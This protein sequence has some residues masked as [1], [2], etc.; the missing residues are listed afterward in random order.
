[1]RPP[2]VSTNDSAFEDS[3]IGMGSR[4]PKHLENMSSDAQPPPSSDHSVS[5]QLSQL[6]AAAWATEQE[7][8]LEGYRRSKI[9]KALRTIERCLDEQEDISEDGTEEIEVVEASS[10]PQSPG[11]WGPEDPEPLQVIQRNLRATVCSMRLRQQEQR[12]LNQVSLEKL[13]SVAQTCFVQEAQLKDMAD[14]VRNLRIENHKLGEMND[15]LHDRV[16]DLESQSTQKEVAV[17]A[18][19]SAV[20]GLEGWINNSPGPNPYQESPSRSQQRRGRYI[21]RGKGRFRGRYYIDD[22]E[23]A[24]DPGHDG[25]SDS[26]ELHDGVKAWLRGFRDVEEE[27]QKVTPDKRR[28]SES[29]RHKLQSAE[30]DWGDFETAS[31]TR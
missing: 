23:E 18:M 3:A 15:T 21:V 6:A 4:T 8:P 22:H 30:D 26:R 9:Q 14:D 25:V 24:A 10:R 1:M 19:S 27:L 20:A 31:E 7:L 5:D 12:H 11:R 2:S 16:A 13:E 29:V 17:N 28:A